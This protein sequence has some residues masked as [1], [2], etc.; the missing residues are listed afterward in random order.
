MTLA[1]LMTVLEFERDYRI[2]HTTTYRLISGAHIEAVKIGRSTL[3]VRE[4]VEKYLETLPR[5]GRKA[6]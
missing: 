2:S 4:S 6:A 5:L 1:K 3:I